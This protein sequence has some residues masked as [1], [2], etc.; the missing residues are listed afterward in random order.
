M[1]LDREVPHYSLR[2]LGIGVVSVLLGTTMYLGAN[3]TV[4]KAATAANSNATGSDAVQADAA[5]KTPASL[6]PSS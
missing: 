6:F 2:K 3:S 4:A 5:S 1:T